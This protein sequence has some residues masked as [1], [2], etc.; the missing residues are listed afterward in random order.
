MGDEIPARGSLRSRGAAAVSAL[1]LQQIS[2]I[3]P[4][5]VIAKTLGANDLLAAGKAG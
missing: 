5:R 3:L 1:T 4:F 2:A